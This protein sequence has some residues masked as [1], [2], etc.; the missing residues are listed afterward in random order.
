[1]V[2]AKRA[3]VAMLLDVAAD[4]IEQGG[5]GE[6][7]FLP[8]A[9]FLAGR[10]R[11]ARI[12]HLGYRIGAHRI[13]KSDDEVAGVEGVELEW[14]GRARRPQAQGVDVL[15][16]PIDDRGVVANRLDRF[17]RLPDVPSALVV[18]VDHIDPAAEANRVIVFEALELPRIAVGQPVF[19]SLL[20]PPSPDDLPEQAI[21]VSDAVAVRGDLEGR[22]AVHETGGETA[23]AAVA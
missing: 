12:E 2:L 21:V 8:Q 1:R 20:L 14:I 19:G 17:G 15:A 22:H 6:E 9:Q 11:I 16:A 3:D 7:V 4:E 18:A 5:G 13:R 23:K 10:R